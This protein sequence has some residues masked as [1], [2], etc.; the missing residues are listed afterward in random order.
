MASD[1]TA[2]VERFDRIVTIVLGDPAM[3]DATDK[4][5]ETL[6]EILATSIR[7]TASEPN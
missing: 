7:S 5:V 4:L 3:L 1:S 6:C 2:A